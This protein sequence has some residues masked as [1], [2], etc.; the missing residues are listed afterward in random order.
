[1]AQPI[2]CPSSYQRVQSSL[3]QNEYQYIAWRHPQWGWANKAFLSSNS[4]PIHHTWSTHHALC[5]LQAQWSHLCS[6]LNPHWQQSYILSSRW[7]D[8][9][10]C[11]WQYPVH[12]AAGQEDGICCE[13][14][15][16]QAARPCRPFFILPWLS[17]KAVLLQSVWDPG[18]GRF[19]LCHLPLCTM[20]DICRSCCN[21]VF[22]KGV[23]ISW[24][25]HSSL[26]KSTHSIKCISQHIQFYQCQ[27]IVDLNQKNL[28]FT[29][30]LYFFSHRIVL[31]L[32]MNISLSSMVQI[33]GLIILYYVVDKFR[34]IW[35]MSNKATRFFLMSEQ[36]WE[37]KC[38]QSLD[39]TAK[40]K[41]C[42]TQATN[43]WVNVTSCFTAA[44]HCSKVKKKRYGY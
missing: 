20:A 43:N 16:T 39:Q 6:I 1:M 44:W 23:C 38:N 12:C 19:W 36:E 25:S 14:A 8:G 17:C 4:S 37:R 15:L 26:L 24:N 7:S 41:D 32:P 22:V 21:S 13:T 9:G 28:F 10:H 29:L 27:A 31:S 34:L 2:W 35:M 30:C 33:Q 11:A 42:I 5:S 40:P 3:W 18:V